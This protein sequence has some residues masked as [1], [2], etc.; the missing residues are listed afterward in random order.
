M[1]QV[2]DFKQRLKVLAEKQRLDRKTTIIDGGTVSYELEFNNELYDTGYGEIDGDCDDGS[3]ETYG[4]NSVTGVKVLSG[5][6]FGIGNNGQ[7]LGE[8]TFDSL[9]D[10]AQFGI[11]EDLL[12][13][14]VQGEVDRDLC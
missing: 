14:M 4:G 9:E 8:Y 11:T 10:L 5:T 12:L 1:R 13:D 3:L 2:N 7:E 6:F